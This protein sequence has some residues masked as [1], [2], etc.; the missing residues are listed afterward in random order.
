MPCMADWCGQCAVIVL[1][2]VFVCS[3]VRG[4]AAASAYGSG[5]ALGGPVVATWT[6]MEVR[7]DQ[8]RGMVLD[9]YYCY[10]FDACYYY[11]HSSYY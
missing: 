8:T 10:P 3:C 11:F 7:G 4:I 5:V 9:Y 2:L 1:V 6:A